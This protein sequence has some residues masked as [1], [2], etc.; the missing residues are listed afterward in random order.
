MLR[1]ILQRLLLFVPTFFGISVFVF[2]LSEQVP[3]DPVKMQ[4]KGGDPAQGM[5]SPQQRISDQAYREMRQRMGWDVP[6]F[7][8]SISD[9]TIPDTLHRIPDPK[10]RERVQR[11][12]WEYGTWEQV[13]AFMKARD[14]LL[15][16]LKKGTSGKKND[17]KIEAK[18]TLYSFFSP[19]TP[20]KI[21]QKLQDLRRI[22]NKGHLWNDH[23]AS[24]Q[25]LEGAF[26]AMVQNRCEWKR[27]LPAF[28]W[29]GS[30]NRYHNWFFGDRPWFGTSDADKEYAGYGVIRGDLGHSFFQGR[31]VGKI[32]WD[33]FSYTFLFGSIA[34]LL[35]YGGSLLIGVYTSVGRHPLKEGP[36]TLLLLLYSMPEFWIG[37]LLITLLADPDLLNLF[38]AAYTL[39][40]IP[41]GAPWWQQGLIHLQHMILPLFCFTY[42]S[43]AYVSRQLKGGMLDAFRS[44]HMRSAIARGIPRGS[45]IWK[46]ALKNA[47]LPIITVFGT[48]LPYLLSG[49]VIIESIFSIP[50]LGRTTYQAL[51]ARDYPV[52]FSMLL[53]SSL[54]TM[55]GTLLSDILYAWADPR[56]A[57]RKKE[58]G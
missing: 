25:A 50:G 49:S 20:E 11:L 33:A 8:F 2:F 1:Y 51:M 40:E 53:F 28:H 9:G 30:E 21:S 54:L 34:I 46:H 17:E 55:I 31:P 58:K 39:M 14:R 5:N 32:L 41:E 4:L 3:G 18:R 19:P 45:R 24:F 22:L 42:G 6:P 7:Y 16:K 37:T 43:L 23:S 35:I 52:I 15:Q 29:H 47:L 27:Y 38:P 12:A 48:L 13:Q 26:H 36:Q 56:I 44:D 10:K 57:Y